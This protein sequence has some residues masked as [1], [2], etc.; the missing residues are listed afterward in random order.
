MH[1]FILFQQLKS[2]K[3]SKYNLDDGEE[4]DTSG[5]QPFADDFNEDV[6]FDDDEDALHGTESMYAMEN[7]SFLA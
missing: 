1:W 5:H 4:N 2:R 6:P 7:R 3:G